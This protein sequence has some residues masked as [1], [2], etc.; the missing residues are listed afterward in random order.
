MCKI[1]FYDV[2][3]HCPRAGILGSKSNNENYLAHNN[4]CLMT[5]TIRRDVR[6]HHVMSPLFGIETR[7]YMDRSRRAWVKGVVYGP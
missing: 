3:S 6:P 4:V 5:I 2:I 7:G 1:L